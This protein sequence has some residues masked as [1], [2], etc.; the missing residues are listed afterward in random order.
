[1]K[2]DYL[3][4][5]RGIA[6]SVL[7]LTILKAGKSVCC[8]D[9]TEMS[10]ASKVAAGLFNPIVFKRTTLS[11][12]AMEA[13]KA[14]EDFY[15]S[16]EK[17]TGISFFHKTGIYRVFG[18]QY[19]MDNWNRL[20]V[21]ESFRAIISGPVESRE[22]PWLIQPYGGANVKEAGFL[23]T[24][25]FL[26]SAERYLHKHAVLV[27]DRFNHQ[28]L[29]IL[30]EG[31]EY[32]GIEASRIVFCEGYLAGI[33]NP[34]FKWLP[35]KPAKGEVIRIYSSRLPEE[36]FTG[37]IYGVPLGNKEFKIGS[38][39]AWDQE[40]ALPT[41]EMRV[42]LEEKLKGIIN[43]PFQLIG[44]YAGIRP[45]VRDRRPLAGC[46]PK[47]KNL[48]IFNGLGTKGVLLAPLI[49]S[50]LCSSLMYNQPLDADYSIARYANLCP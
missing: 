49:A 23:D 47:Y 2:V 29:Q 34:W 39:Y 21:S 8:I 17:D 41:E 11:W 46:H 43:V 35:F 38:T 1:M 22:R 10:G 37:S 5:G 9:A 18:T 30:D 50:E 7:A 32:M 40:D 31:V 13:L 16:V 28:H 42:F 19:E 6:G 3:L 4:A 20:S 15:S 33:N 45:T 27:N 36:P 12:R 26:R 48:F 14:A 24:E 44:H 25:L